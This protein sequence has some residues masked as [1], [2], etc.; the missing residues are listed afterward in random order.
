MGLGSEIRDPE[1]TYSGARTRGQKG[2]GS[3]IRIRNTGHKADYNT[4][5]GW[6]WCHPTSFTVIRFLSTNA[7]FGICTVVD[8]N[9][10]LVED[11]MRSTF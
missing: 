11:K 9:G 1:K 4:G 6:G 7:K 8:L 3:R 2:T 5:E 10:T